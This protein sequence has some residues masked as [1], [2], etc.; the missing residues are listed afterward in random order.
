MTPQQKNIW[1]FILESTKNNIEVA[2]LFVLESKGSSPGRQGFFMA[3]NSKGEMEGSIGGGIMEHKLVELVKENLNEGKAINLIKKQL[4]HKAAA[5]NQSG[6]V[7]SGE[8]TIFLYSIKKEDI[9]VVQKIVNGNALS[10]SL[11]ANGISF[12][13][14]KVPNNYTFIFNSETDWLYTENLSFKNQLHIIGGGHCSLALSKLM[15][16]M[17]FAIAVYDTRE[18]LST[19]TKNIFATQKTIVNDYTEL[20]DLIK[21]GATTFVIIMTLGYRTDTIAFDALY[22]KEFSYFKILG[23]ATKL[24]TLYNEYLTKGIAENKLTALL[25]P[26]GVSIYSQTPQEIAISI[27]AEIIAVK[28]KTSK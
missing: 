16:E 8:Q 26:A 17:D 3:V 11:S 25:Q 4:H 23:S 10:I 21:E 1:Q 24:Q 12:S 14:E 9:V 6:M 18:N 19:I 28:N 5:A 22:N 7:C 2:L 27:A 13:M 20:K 15:S